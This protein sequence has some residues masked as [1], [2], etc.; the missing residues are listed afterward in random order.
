MLSVVYGE[1]EMFVWWCGCKKGL[2]VAKMLD[3]GELFEDRMY[4]VEFFARRCSGI[5]CVGCGEE[6]RE[7]RRERRRE[8]V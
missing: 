5:K 7:R 1:G 6:E 2:V 4:G 3:E 8:G